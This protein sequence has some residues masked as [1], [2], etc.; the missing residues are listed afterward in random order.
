[1]TLFLLDVNRS[2]PAREPQ[3][4]P[5]DGKRLPHRGLLKSKLVPLWTVLPPPIPLPPETSSWR[6]SATCARVSLS[7]AKQLPALLNRRDVPINILIS[8]REDSLASLDPFKGEIP[9]LFDNYLR[10]EYLS[11]E[12]AKEAVLKP[13]ERF[14]RAYPKRAM[15]M[16]EDLAETVV[17]QII[18]AQGEKAKRV[19]T[20]TLQL[21][22][23]RWWKREDELQSGV[24]AG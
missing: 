16:S 3:P 19:Q 10:V 8:I 21:I 18:N 6:S 22:L 7:F 11:R 1:M 2:F 14:N 4:G 5:A 9:N 23:S 15:A 13:L 24:P 20:P 17:L 12:A